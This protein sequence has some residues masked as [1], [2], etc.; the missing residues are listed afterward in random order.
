MILEMAPALLALAMARDNSAQESHGPIP[1]GQ[2][3]Q[4]E[5]ALPTPRGQVVMLGE[6]HGSNETP[7][8][9]LDLV[10]RAARDNP[11]T[12]GLELPPATARLGCRGTGPRR[13]PAY[14]DDGNQDGRKSRAMRDLVCALRAPPLGRRVRVVFLD[15]DR[16]RAE[17]D[18]VAARRFARSFAPRRAVGLILTGS[19]HARN[20]AGSMAAHLRQSGLDVRTVIVS[21]PAVEVWACVGE[22]PCGVRNVAVNFCS[23]GAAARAETR[24]MAV[25]DARLPWDL[26]LSIPRLTASPPAA[27]AAAPTS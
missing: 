19:Y 25:L 2:T 13:L 15:D 22:A 24:W 18:A 27:G 12:V 7:S 17:F 1:P 26:C 20:V 6:M 23:A 4:Y 8:Y 11:V 9:F 16:R 5:A 3:N 14:W 21:S 10:R